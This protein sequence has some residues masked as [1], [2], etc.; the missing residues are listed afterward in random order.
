MRIESDM[1]D[2]KSGAAALFLTDHEPLMVGLPFHVLKQ[3]LFQYRQE[4]LVQRRQ[5]VR[6]GIV[7]P[8]AFATITQP[9]GVLQVSEMP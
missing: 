6:H 2:K 1:P 7:D 3:K 5:G 8:D 4:A 9:A